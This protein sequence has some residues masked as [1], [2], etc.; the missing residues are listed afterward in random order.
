MSSL[1][2]WSSSVYTFNKRNLFLLN[3]NEKKT[4]EL[5]YH[6][7]SSNLSYNKATSSIKIINLRSL[8]NDYFSKFILNKFLLFKNILS[9]FNVE[10][11]NFSF[12]SD[13]NYIEKIRSKVLIKKTLRLTRLFKYRMRK[14]FYSRFFKNRSVN[15]VYVSKPEIKY[16]IKE[17]IV[18]VYVYNRERF[19]FLKKLSKLNEI[20]F[21]MLKRNETYDKL[22]S[23]E[24][25]KSLLIEKLRPIQV[26]RNEDLM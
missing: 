26:V 19:Y 6:Y 25:S 8:Y 13:N 16:S 15:K 12:F 4:Y 10:K 9:I 14:R 11:K 17:V 7:F 1:S 21:N 22:E 2:E 5:L 24:T 18:T 3:G 23:D 20:I